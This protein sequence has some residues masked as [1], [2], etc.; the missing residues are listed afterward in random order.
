[1][2]ADAQCCPEGSH[3]NRVDPHPTVDR[4]RGGEQD[5]DDVDEEAA[6]LLP[7][8]QVDG[9]GVGQLEHHP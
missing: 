6:V 1:M 4:G 2:T 3:S 8:D 5:G 9:V 7:A